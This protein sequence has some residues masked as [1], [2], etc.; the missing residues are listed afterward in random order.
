MYNCHGCNKHGL[1]LVERNSVKMSERMPIISAPNIGGRLLLS[2]IQ[3]ENSVNFN[4]NLRIISAFSLYR[5]YSLCGILF[6]L[7]GHSEFA[8]LDI[9]KLSTRF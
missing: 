6:F 3:K 9:I 7:Y 5:F 2:S 1:F 4:L 8:T